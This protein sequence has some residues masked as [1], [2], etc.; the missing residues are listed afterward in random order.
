MIFAVTLV[1]SI[2]FLLFELLAF[3]SA[4]RYP[5]DLGKFT[6]NLQRIVLCVLDIIF[7]VCILV[8]YLVNPNNEITMC[9]LLFGQII[10][11]FVYIIILSSLCRKKHFNNI[12]DEIKR[13]NL[14]INEDIIELRR[15]LMANSELW[16]SMEDLNKIINRLQNK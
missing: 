1:V 11:G 4:V 2:L 13:L 14:D 16:C 7:A 10:V 6:Y 8:A 15:K 5:V 3:A 12:I 9:I